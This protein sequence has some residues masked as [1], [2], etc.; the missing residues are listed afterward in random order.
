MANDAFVQTTIPVEFTLLAGASSC[1]S[2]PCCPYMT[3]RWSSTFG[4]QE[5]TVLLSNERP[6]RRTWHP[7]RAVPDGGCPSQVTSCSCSRM[8]DH[9]PARHG[10]LTMQNCLAE[11]LFAERARD[12]TA[13]S[14]SRVGWL[15][16][17]KCCHRQSLRW[18]VTRPDR[19]GSDRA[20]SGDGRARNPHPSSSLRWTA[21]HHPVACGPGIRRSFTPSSGPLP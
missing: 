2:T 20:G 10:I 7:A 15:P 18:P 11:A 13:A 6:T 9:G 14:M 1:P 5:S 12:G 4:L 21:V 17:S 3:E 16:E 19:G 8:V